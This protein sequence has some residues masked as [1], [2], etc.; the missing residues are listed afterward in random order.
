M[1][2][3]QEIYQLFSCILQMALIVSYGD[4]RVTNIH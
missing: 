1:H 2:P 4:E 3:D